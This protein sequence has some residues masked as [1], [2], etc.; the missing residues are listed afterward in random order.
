MWRDNLVEWNTY[1]ISNFREIIFRLGSMN[2]LPPGLK[3]QQSSRGL[4]CPSNLWELGRFVFET[5]KFH[6]FQLKKLK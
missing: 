1:K 6:L 3:R 2:I 5:V 4:Y